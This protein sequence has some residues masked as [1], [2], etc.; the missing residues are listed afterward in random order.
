[1]DKSPKPRI[2]LS[3]RGVILLLVAILAIFVVLYL[4]IGATAFLR[5]QLQ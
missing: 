2:L 3:K 5:M 4:G 1:M